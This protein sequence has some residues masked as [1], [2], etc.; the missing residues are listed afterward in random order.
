M[1]RVTDKN[2]KGVNLT[3]EHDHRKSECTLPESADAQLKLTHDEALALICHYNWGYNGH[4]VC[5]CPMCTDRWGKE[6]KKKAERAEG[7]REARAALED[8]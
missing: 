2:D 4:G 6:S 3:E 1:V 8:I 5:G 7:K